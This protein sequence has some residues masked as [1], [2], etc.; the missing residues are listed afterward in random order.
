MLAQVITSSQQTLKL[1]GVLLFLSLLLIIINYLEIFSGAFPS[2]LGTVHESIILFTNKAMC[3][4]DS[5][6]LCQFRMLIFQA[7]IS[8]FISYQGFTFCQGAN[9]LHLTLSFATWICPMMMKQYVGRGPFSQLSPPWERASCQR[10]YYL[11][12]FTREAF[13]SPAFPSLLVSRLQH[14][15]LK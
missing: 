5:S 6:F 10:L 7:I 13:A 8:Q 9:Y 15:Y 2:L 3:S 4:I 1:S 11:K 14:K 12:S